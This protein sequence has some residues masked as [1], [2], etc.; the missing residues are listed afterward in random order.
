M[1]QGEVASSM[2]CWRIALILSRSDEQLV[3]LVLAEHA[4]QRRLCDL[5]RRDH[6]VLDLDDRVLGL[7]DPEVGDGVDAHRA[8]CPS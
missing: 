5:R 1:P 8:R 2:I 7:D 3:E 6:E 4:P